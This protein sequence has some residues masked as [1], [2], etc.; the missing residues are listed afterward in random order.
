MRIIATRVSPNQ[1]NGRSG[2]TPT[3]FVLHTS[4]NTTQSGVNTVMNAANQVSYHAIVAGRNFG[5]HGIVPAYTNGDIIE[6][7][8]IRNTAWHAGTNATNPSDNRH[9]SH[10]TVAA[11]RNSGRNTND[12]TIG[13]A[14]GDFFGTN[15]TGGVPTTEQIQS[16]AWL[17][18]RYRD[19]V[20]R[21]FNHTILLTRDF[22]LGHD[23]V[24]PRTRPDCP[25]R[26]F[27]W[28]ALIAEINRQEGAA[29]TPP[30]VPTPPPTGPE[31]DMNVS[32]WAREGWIWAMKELNMDGTRPR[33]NITRQEVM[34]LLFRLHN[35][36][37][38][39]TSSC[40][41]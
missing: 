38:S 32:D 19:E 7:V 21:V 1:R 4:G 16:A 10:S 34:T 28:A 29:T 31:V 26:N 36:L 15:N 12:F 20:R 18:R 5:G 35:V 41:D 3:H 37:I 8:D 9:N 14:F 13:I 2:Q 17:I 30:P 23:Q 33:D 22:I 6:L 40:S 11:I 25:G 27:P 24:T 39:N